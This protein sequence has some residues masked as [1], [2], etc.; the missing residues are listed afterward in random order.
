MVNHQDMA[1]LDCLDGSNFIRL[2]EKEK[3]ISSNNPQGV[4]YICKFMFVPSLT[5][6]LL[7]LEIR[8]A[9]QS[10]LFHLHHT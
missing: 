5:H 1:V 4:S 3:S 6:H 9:D 7:L 10:M 8:M 2:K